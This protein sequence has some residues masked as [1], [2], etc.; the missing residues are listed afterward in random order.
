MN[1]YMK[2]DVTATIRNQ[3]KTNVEAE[4]LQDNGNVRLIYNMKFS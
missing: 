4:M 2:S 3:R 1:Q